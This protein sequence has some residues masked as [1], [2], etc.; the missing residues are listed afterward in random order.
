MASGG[1]RAKFYCDF[2][3]FWKPPPQSRG[4]VAQKSCGCRLGLWEEAA[5]VWYKIAVKRLDTRS[6][7]T[8][9][10]EFPCQ[11]PS[12]PQCGSSPF[13]CTC[14]LRQEHFSWS[15]WILKKWKFSELWHP[16]CYLE[17]LEHSLVVIHCALTLFISQKALFPFHNTAWKEEYSIYH[18]SV[19]S[20]LFSSFLMGILVEFRI[21]IPCSTALRT[22]DDV[23]WTQRGFSAGLY[24][25]H[26]NSKPNLGTLNAWAS[27]GDVTW[28]LP[29][30]DVCAVPDLLSSLENGCC[31]CL[32]SLL[33]SSS[34][35][36]FKHQHILWFLINFLNKKATLRG[37]YC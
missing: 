8:L 37:S 10:I 26:Q 3:A 13:Y 2:F 23:N 21:V 19:L 16:V 30:R 33:P 34:L 28:S 4:A 18:P 9:G 24:K 12:V 27:L 25:R 29:G 32:K 15:I 6:K 5:L 35:L 17:L 11:V 1:F 14:F 20:L 7:W 36:E 31:W 22:Q